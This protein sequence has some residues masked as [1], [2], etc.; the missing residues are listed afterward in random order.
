V[1][2]PAFLS[3]YDRYPL[4]EPAPLFRKMDEGVSEEEC[5]RLAG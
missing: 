5:A 4:R 2:V 1:E 3:R